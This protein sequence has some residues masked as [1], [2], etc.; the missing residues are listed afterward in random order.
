MNFQGKLMK[1]GV[2]VKVFF[3]KLHDFR[4]FHFY[5]LRPEAQMAFECPQ[6]MESKR[7]HPQK[8]CA[9]PHK[10]RQFF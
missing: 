3:Q 1:K 2:K 9:I 4:S 8:P 10:A 5:H 7:P 6:K